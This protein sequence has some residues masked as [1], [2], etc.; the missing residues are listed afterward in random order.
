LR[1]GHKTRLARLSVPIDDTEAREAQHRN[2]L[3][4][5]AVLCGI[6]RD[7]MLRAGVDPAS[8]RALCEHEARLAG[9]VDTPELQRA[10]AELRAAQDRWKDGQGEAV[11][12]MLLARLDNI[13]R[14]FANGSLPDFAR[15]PFMVLFAWA[16]E[17]KPDPCNAA[18][19]GC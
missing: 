5:Y 6:V 13:G 11:R 1:A 14:H 10:D 16:T 15:D 7:A 2:M 19:A 3:R 17:R 18:D 9:F 4:F 12:E 8:A